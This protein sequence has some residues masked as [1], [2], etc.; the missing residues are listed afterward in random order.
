M[1]TVLPVFLFVLKHIFLAD[2]R[3]FGVLDSLDGLLRLAWNPNLYGDYNPFCDKGFCW[4]HVAWGAGQFRWTPYPVSVTIRD[5]VN[6]YVGPLIFVK[7]HYY[8]EGVHFTDNPWG[9]KSINNT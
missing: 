9:S 7:H 2:F 1:A 5:S 4:V 8:R 6:F 3:F